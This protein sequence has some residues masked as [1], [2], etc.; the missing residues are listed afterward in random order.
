MS[1]TSVSGIDIGGFFDGRVRAGF[2]MGKGHLFSSSETCLSTNILLYGR[3]QGWN[4]V[5]FRADALSLFINPDDYLFGIVWLG[6][7]STSLLLDYRQSAK[8][9]ITMRLFE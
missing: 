5:C 9:H 2:L 7:I 8:S 6:D 3:G 4:V 1:E